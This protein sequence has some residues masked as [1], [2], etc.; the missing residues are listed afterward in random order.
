MADSTV[1]TMDAGDGWQK[2][3]KL[4][5]ATYQ[6]QGRPAFAVPHPER[7][8][9]E[10]SLADFQWG[11]C[12]VVW[13]PSSSPGALDRLE[14]ANQLETWLSTDDVLTQ[15]FLR[16]VICVSAQPAEKPVSGNLDSSETVT[17]FPGSGLGCNKLTDLGVERFTCIRLANHTRPGI[18]QIQ[19]GPYVWDRGQFHR[20][21]RLF[22]DTQ[23]AFFSAIIQE[24]EGA[25]ATFSE[26]RPTCSIPVPSRLYF[27]PRSD[28]KPLSGLR[29]GVKDVFDMAGLRTSLGSRSYYRLC[30]AK[31]T[32]ADAINH[33]TRL[34][35][36]VV[37]KTK[38]TS[39]VSGEDPQEWID[40]SCPWNPRGDGYQNPDT[41]SSG[42]AAAVATYPWLDFAIGSDTCGSICCP[43]ASQGV[44][45]LRGSTGSIS[46]G[47]AFVL[48]PSLDSAGVFCRTMRDL[49]V[50]SKTWEA[51]SMAI[52]LTPDEKLKPLAILY[53]WP[54]FPHLNAEV[55]SQVDQFISHLERYTG[56]RRTVLDMDHEWTNDD[57]SGTGLPL[58][59]YLRH[60]TALLHLA[61]INDSATSFEAEYR[62][63][64]SR[65]PYFDRVTAEAL[66]LAKKVTQKQRASMMHEQKV[67]S[68]WL[69]DK[70]LRKGGRHCLGAIMIW[71]FSPQEPQYRDNYPPVSPH[72][73][74]KWDIDFSGPLAALPQAVLPIGQF[75]YH[76]RVTDHIELLPTAV[77][78]A[79]PHGT[80][81][82]LLDFLQRFLNDCDLP[83]T[84]M[85][86]KLAYPN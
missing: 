75:N 30:Q 61:G 49:A 12:V 76:S 36:I 45:G 65:A 11:P 35:A 34:G 29:F 40:Y 58:S 67:L 21:F 60:T 10:R 44:Y 86:G 68:T 79:S 2:V 23:E 64:F 85:P 50:I 8:I 84:V 4:E 54:S 77:S 28:Q 5:N 82:A 48:A 20:V 39:F 16:E 46:R 41:S 74:W 27:P 18:P 42:S 69:N 32:T 53:P 73:N 17:A 24:G 26:Q 72:V 13:S 52:P 83:S 55:L 15:P 7:R 47:G 56:L 14:L 1:F 59:E 22:E 43:A 19:S 57:P 37:G 3:L 63:K 9:L 51:L 62:A 81:H 6:V 70:I 31:L 33:L 66:K 78:V 71:P 25:S 38:N 80:D